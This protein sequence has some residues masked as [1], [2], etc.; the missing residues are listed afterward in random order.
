MEAKE[1]SNVQAWWHSIARYDFQSRNDGRPARCASLFF[2]RPAAGLWL[3]EGRTEALRSLAFSVYLD[4]VR[5]LLDARPPG[6]ISSPWDLTKRESGAPATCD[7]RF[8]PSEPCSN[9]QL[10]ARDRPRWADLHREPHS[11]LA[12]P[13][14]THELFR[15]R[16]HGANNLHAGASS[17]YGLRGK[18]A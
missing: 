11:G 6:S 2:Q 18:T 16:P 7:I 10:L 3:N 4:V 8:E 9:Q 1:D 14:A 15:H 13:G 5:N 12:Y 17:P